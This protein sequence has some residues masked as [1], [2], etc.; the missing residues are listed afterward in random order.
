MK[1][2][3]VRLTNLRGERVRVFK[4][5]DG[6]VRILQQESI[7]VVVDPGMPEN[8]IFAFDPGRVRI[9]GTAIEAAV[10]NVIVRG[11]MDWRMRR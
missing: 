1:R 8:T 4:D 11:Q 5:E 3:T 6:K 2:R 7:N 9:E 10:R